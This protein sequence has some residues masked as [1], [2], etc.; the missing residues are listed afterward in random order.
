VDFKDLK[1]GFP[2]RCGGRKEEGAL[3][4]RV[5]LFARVWAVVGMVTDVAL[6]VNSFV[7]KTAGYEGD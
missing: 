4:G 7:R 6:I 2:Q 3:S 1:G 5:A